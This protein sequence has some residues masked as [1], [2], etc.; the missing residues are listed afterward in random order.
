LPATP[1][2][3]RP[4][5]VNLKRFYAPDLVFNLGISRRSV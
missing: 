3:S 2:F 1:A 4:V 5:A